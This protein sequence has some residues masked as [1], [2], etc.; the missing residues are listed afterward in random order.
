MQFY[1][2]TDL[3]DLKRFED[4]VVKLGSGE[5]AKITL[6]TL[7][8]VGNKA[9]TEVKHMTMQQ[10]GLRVGDAG[11]AWRVERPYVGHL[12][13][14]IEGSGKF[15][16]LEYFGAHATRRFMGRGKLAGGGVTAAPWNKARLF[17]KAFFAGDQVF[18]RVGPDRHDI[19]KM[20]GGAV[21][22]EMERDEVPKIARHYAEEVFPEAFFRKVEQF[23]PR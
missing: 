6:Y 13:Y 15:F 12:F 19:K 2:R 20:F 4:A 22:R 23:L 11:G 5:I 8:D 7:R 10:L 9:F 18:K 17:P 14:T 21:P 3:R 1:F 16:G